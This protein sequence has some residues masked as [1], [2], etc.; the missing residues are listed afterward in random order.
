MLERVSR[1][2]GV[3][4]VVL[5][6]S[7][8]RLGDA[9]GNSILFVIIPLYVAKLPA[10]AFGLP[11][12]ARVGVVL[13]LYGL[14]AAVGQPLVGALS[15][16]IGRR[17]PLI[18][19]G[20]VAMA[21][22]T[23]AFTLA[24]RFADLL[25]LRGLQGLAVAFTIPTSLA[26]MSSATEKRTRGGSMG[27]YSTMRIVGL[28]TGPLL[29][30]LLYDHVGFNAAFYAGTGFVALGAL[31]VQLWVDEVPG[32]PSEQGSRSFRLFDPDVLSS[33]VVGLGFA[34]FAMAVAFSMMGALETEINQRL[35]QTALAFG[36]AFSALMVSRLL[37]QIPLGRW[38]DR[39]GRK[40]FLL[41]GL[42]LMAPATALL[43]YATTTGQLVLLRVAQGLAS[44]G[45]A[46]PAFALA[47]DLSR[48][49]GEGRQM[50]VITT[51]FG[52]GLALGP[53]LAGV[54]GVS[55]FAL[56][57]VVGGAL[58]LAGAGIVLRFVPESVRRPVGRA[59]AR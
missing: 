16:R 34:T 44:A 57:F 2:I 35:D 25:L 49:G 54:L 43:G 9:I 26:I 50:S 28:A 37:L 27:V 53:L 3:N 52:L 55:D 40:P 14:V 47:A 17:K 39:I 56:P 13:A 22:C 24:G 5:A 4:R 59:A 48:R 19:G 23:L 51:G 11:R 32:E 42:V 33:G 15:D 6:L 29:A 10:P 1:S 20:L 30:G 36:L 21:L 12:S 46:A 7:F 41:V 38:S 58:S 31:L 45:I 18:L 8:A